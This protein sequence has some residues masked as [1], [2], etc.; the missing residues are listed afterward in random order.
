M[1]VRSSRYYFWLRN[2]SPPGRSTRLPVSTALNPDLCSIGFAAVLVSRQHVSRSKY[3]PATLPHQPAVTSTLC[4]TLL[5]QISTEGNYTPLIVKI[6]GS[7][8]QSSQ[9]AS[10]WQDYLTDAESCIFPTLIEQSARPTGSQRRTKP[11]DASS[12]NADVTIA[13]WAVLLGRYLAADNV[14]FGLVFNRAGAQ[15]YSACRIP[16][17]ED[18]SLSSVVAGTKEALQSCIAFSFQHMSEFESVLG[19]ENQLF[20]TSVRLDFRDSEPTTHVS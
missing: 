9:R 4:P 18:T 1:Y 2:S 5:L 13:A 7:L 20:N 10:F 16:L 3:L 17:P 11:I 19:L 12:C 14:C 15:Q 8:P 6:M